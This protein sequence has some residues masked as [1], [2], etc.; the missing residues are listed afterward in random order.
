MLYECD[1]IAK[2]E[3]TCI[4]DTIKNKLKKT[5]DKYDDTHY[6]ANMQQ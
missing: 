4:F 1:K 6:N 5:I 3:Y 2:F